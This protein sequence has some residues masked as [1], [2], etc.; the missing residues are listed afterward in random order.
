MSNSRYFKPCKSKKGVPLKLFLIIPFFAFLIMGC[1]KII[2]YIPPIEPAVVHTN[3]ET[4]SI[5]QNNQLPEFINK[6]SNIPSP[7]SNLKYITQTANRFE[8][9]F[10]DGRYIILSNN[11][12]P[13]ILRCDDGNSMLPVF[14]C[15]DKVIL[16]E[17]TTKEEVELGD[18][19]VYHNPENRLIIHRVVRIENNNYFTRGDNFDNTLRTINNN[20]DIDDVP[21]SFEKIKYKVVGIIYD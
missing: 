3:F 14:D 2:T 10:D 5:P 17:V 13:L 21:I 20:L 11:T 7:T 18:I 4:P 15:D 19:I 1:N 16:K 9:K 6:I 12:S 8:V